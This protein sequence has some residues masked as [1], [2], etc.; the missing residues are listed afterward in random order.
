MPA[1]SYYILSVAI[2][3]VFFFLMWGVLRDSGV[4]A[5]WMTAGVASSILIIG[6]VLLRELVLRRGRAPEASAAPVSR[7]SDIRAQGKLTIDGNRLLLQEIKK[8]SDAANVLDKFSAG[9]RQV[10]ELCGEYLNLI[11]EEL[12]RMNAGSPRLEPLLKGR[13]R[14]VEAHRFHMLRWAELEATELTLKAQ[15]GPE[16]LASAKEAL[17]VVETALASYPQERALNESKGLLT[18]M[19]VSIGVRDLIENAEEAMRLE[20]FSTAKSYYRDALHLLARDNIHT[21]ERSAAADRIRAEIERV[22]ALE[23]TDR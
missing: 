21:P 4:E 8:R 6:A 22:T 7:I 16:K 23:A 20:E 2:A 13:T 11:E 18:E 15:A 10:F 9:H 3:S 19:V 17:L 12:G 1:S 14:A 5:P